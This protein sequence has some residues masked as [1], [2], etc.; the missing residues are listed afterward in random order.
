M[1]VACQFRVRTAGSPRPELLSALTDRLQRGSDIPGTYGALAYLVADGS[2]LLALAPM[3]ALLL[4]RDICG[5]A[6]KPLDATIISSISGRV[7][8][9]LR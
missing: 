6:Q 5:A 4:T 3:D 9:L 2:P 8:L 7:A 1:R